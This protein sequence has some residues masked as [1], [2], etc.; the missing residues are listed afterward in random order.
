MPKVD[1]PPE[2]VVLIQSVCTHWEKTERGGASAVQ[3]NR[4]PE[5]LRLPIFRPESVLISY[6]LHCVDYGGRNGFAEPTR[7]MVKVLTTEPARLGSVSLAVDADILTVF[8]QYRR[9]QGAPER[10]SRR[11]EVLKLSLNQWGRVLYNGRHTGTEGYWCY[12]KWVY[13]VGLFSSPSPS[14]F[15]TTEPVKAFTQM[16]HL[17]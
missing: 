2:L 10:Y 14:V 8:Y 11:I 9:G 13:N 1:D 17:W 3:R 4:V 6:V 16:A 15:L 12:E 5:A 7:S